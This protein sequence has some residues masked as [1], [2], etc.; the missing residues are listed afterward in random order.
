M[1]RP[2]PDEQ[3]TRVIPRQTVE[4]PAV[5]TAPATR[6]AGAWHK[7]LPARIGRARTS[8][9]VI[10]CLFLVLFALNSALPGE[11]TGTTPVTTS[12]GRVIQVPNSVLPSQARSTPTP[13]APV[14]S[15]A[16]A[17]TQEPAAPS[18]TPATTS[19]APRTT[20]PA[21]TTAGDEGSA[22]PSATGERSAP[23]PTTSR[24]PATSRAPSSTAEAPTA[25][26]PTSAPTS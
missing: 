14:T 20:A 21:S 12:D 11:A 18:S 16:P 2:T 1:S 6:R 26:E 8:T 24:A 13:T 7:R 19:R 17:T 5:S 3:P 10:S 9:V 23:A 15:R 4:Q 25:G 22:A